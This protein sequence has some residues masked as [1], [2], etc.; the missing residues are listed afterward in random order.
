[1]SLLIYAH[2]DS[3]DAAELGAMRLKNRVKGVRVA[4]I[5]KNHYADDSEETTLS[6]FPQNGGMADA[7][8]FGSI[9]SVPYAAFV[10]ESSRDERIEPSERGDAYLRVEAEDVP[11]AREAAAVL[12]TTGGREIRIREK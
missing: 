12:R 3:V 9:Y 10:N 11:T 5:S 2:Y 7:F 6:L 4:G 8:P 1:M